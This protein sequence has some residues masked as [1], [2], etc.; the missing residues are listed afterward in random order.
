MTILIE[1]QLPVKKD[2]QLN[3]NPNGIRKFNGGSI[4][5]D[6]DSK[7]MKNRGLVVGNQA[8]VRTGQ[9][10]IAKDFTSFNSWWKGSCIDRPKDKS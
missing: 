6:D 4:P 3:T 9:S 1:R 2:I 10:A 7:R 8:K 5:W